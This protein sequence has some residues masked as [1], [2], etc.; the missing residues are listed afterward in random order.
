M[1][2]F[3]VGYEANC[4]QSCITTL[5][6]RNMVRPFKEGMLNQACPMSDVL[7]AL[8]EQ[9]NE[10]KILKENVEFEMAPS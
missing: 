1:C 8:A 6:L 10:L 7:D 9:L 4:A 2:P 3:L 5:A